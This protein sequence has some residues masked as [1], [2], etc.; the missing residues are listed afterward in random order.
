MMVVVLI[1]LFI[2]YF[3]WRFIFVRFSK[4]PNQFNGVLNERMIS[5]MKIILLIRCLISIYLYGADVVFAMEKSTFMQWVIILL[6]S[7]LL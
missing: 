4:V 2:R 7:L 6:F 5:I 1:C 3:Y